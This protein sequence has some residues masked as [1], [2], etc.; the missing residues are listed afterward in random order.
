M[1]RLGSREPSSTDQHLLRKGQFGPRARRVVAHL[2]RHSGLGQLKSSEMELDALLPF[3][4]SFL[5]WTYRV[6]PVHP[7]KVASKRWYRNCTQCVGQRHLGRHNASCMDDCARASRVRHEMYSCFRALRSLGPG[8]YAPFLSVSLATVQPDA[9]FLIH[10]LHP[11]SI[12]TRGLRSF[13]SG[14]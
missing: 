12:H 4:H 2:Q 14:A 1:A 9:P 7:V 8:V 6:G 10:Y 3:S 13:S 11:K 5:S